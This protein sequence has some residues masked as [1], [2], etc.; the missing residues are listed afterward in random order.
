MPSVLSK[1]LGVLSTRQELASSVYTWENRTKRV[2]VSC[3]QTQSL[4]LGLCLL[5]AKLWELLISGMCAEQRA[6]VRWFNWFDLYTAPLKRYL[7]VKSVWCSEEADVPSIPIASIRS[8]FHKCPSRGQQCLQCPVLLRARPGVR[9]NVWSWVCNI[10]S[11]VL[12]SDFFPDRCRKSVVE[13]GTEPVPVLWE[14]V[15]LTRHRHGPT[16]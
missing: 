8:G 10:F 14:A 4:A 5:S 9:S 12:L 2:Y 11:D 7:N 6:T 16:K 1:C 13:L 15:P 3:F